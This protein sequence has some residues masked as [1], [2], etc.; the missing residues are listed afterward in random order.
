MRLTS[1]V[2]QRGLL[3]P[4]PQT[5]DIVIERDLRIPMP[6]GAIQLADRWALRAGGTALPTAVYRS[7]YVAGRRA[8]GLSRS[9]APLGGHPAGQDRGLWTLAAAQRQRGHAVPR[10]D[11]R[12]TAWGWPALVS[13]IRP[14]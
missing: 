14:G 3:L 1:Y 12:A 2:I 6:D 11:A 8:G 5:R 4:P 7:P 9:R 10:S 13:L